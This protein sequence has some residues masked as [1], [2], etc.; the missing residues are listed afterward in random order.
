MPTQNSLFDMFET[1]PEPPEPPQEAEPPQEPEPEAA[2]DPEVRRRI[3]ALVPCR[4]CPRKTGRE[5][6]AFSGGLCMVCS[7]V[8]S[9]DWM[10]ER[11]RARSKEGVG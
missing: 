2:N 6:A 4:E 9:G 1:E 8:E 10:A 5:W 3:D 7:P 11:R